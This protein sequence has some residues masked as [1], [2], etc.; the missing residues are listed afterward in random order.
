MSKSKIAEGGWGGGGGQ[1]LEWLLVQGCSPR[2]PANK[3]AQT[4]II[5]LHHDYLFICPQP[6]V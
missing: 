5:N 1:Y 3:L 4:F 6:A 2:Q